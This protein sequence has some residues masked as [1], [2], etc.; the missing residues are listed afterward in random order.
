MFARDPSVATSSSSSADPAVEKQRRAADEQ[1]GRLR[2]Q[3][4]DDD[5]LVKSSKAVHSAVKLCGAKRSVGPDFVSLDERKFCEM[6]SK[7]LYEF[8]EEVESGECWDDEN[9]VLTDKTAG[10]SALDSAR[11]KPISKYGDVINWE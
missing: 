7:T 1:Y 5:R 4:A 3:M 10:V 11:V 8:C 9:I 2:R 6:K